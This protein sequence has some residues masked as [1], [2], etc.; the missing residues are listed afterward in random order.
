MNGERPKGGRSDFLYRYARPT[1]SIELAVQRIL[2][3]VVTGETEPTDLHKVGRGVRILSNLDLEES[4]RRKLMAFARQRIAKHGVAERRDHALHYLALLFVI[5]PDVALDDLARWLSAEGVQDRADHAERT[6]G[7]LF[8]RHDPLVSNLRE[9]SSVST[10]ARLLRL[11]YTYIRPEQDENHRGSFT[12]GRRDH[13]EGARNLILG[14]LLNS[15]GPDAYLALCRV[16]ADP[17]YSVRGDRFRELARGMAERDT[18][19]PPWTGKEVAA[20]EGDHTAPAKTGIDLFNLVVRVLQNIQHGLDNS[21]VSSRSLLQAATSEDQVRNWMMEQM[22]ARAKG[23]FHAFREAQ[24]AES[25]RPDV[26]VAS[27][28]AQCEVALEV[29]HSGK[30]WTLRQYERALRVQLAEDYLRQP[31]RRHGV[32]VV[33]K[34]KDRRW[35]DSETN[36]GVTFEQLIARLTS[37][38]AT[39]TINA[40]GDAITVGCFGLDASDKTQKTRS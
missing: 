26:I 32:F 13:A 22:N 37:L 25:N 23:R 31:S 2:L 21:D 34:H 3:S 33:S 18:E 30:G 28:S 11:A 35:R 5:S 12:P 29:K 15:F 7:A 19:P 6:F 16:A 20:F 4:Q 9:R 8:D 24:I 36:E 38:A 40:N 10:L 27:T 1:S 14:A 39:L 17:A